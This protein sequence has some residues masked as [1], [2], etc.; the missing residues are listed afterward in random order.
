MAEPVRQYIASPPTFRAHDAGAAVAARQV[1]NWIA[2][3][4]RLL[5][6]E[7]VGSSSV[8]GCGGK[9]S[10]DLL[11]IYPDGLLEAAKR[12]LANLGF[13]RQQS[14]DPFPEDRPM[15]VGSVEHAGRSY[16]VHAHVVAASSPEVEELLWFR[17]RLRSDA[18]LQGAYEAEKKRILAEG[19]LDLTEYAEKK[20][21]FV[22]RVLSERKASALGDGAIKDALNRKL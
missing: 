21:A 6:A 1:I 18:A 8:P 2:A 22:Q 16:P 10:I 3:N 7:H 19:V 20:G 11:V 12:L 5:R 13:Q 4:D 14:R 17:E 9:G 15:R